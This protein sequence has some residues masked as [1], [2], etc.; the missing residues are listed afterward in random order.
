MIF[1][2]FRDCVN[3][4]NYAGKLLFFLCSQNNSVEGKKPEE[5]ITE[6]EPLADLC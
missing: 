4:S 6:T 5:S 1:L 2:S 3:C